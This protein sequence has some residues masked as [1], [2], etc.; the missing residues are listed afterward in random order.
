MKYTLTVDQPKTGDD[1]ST[2]SVSTYDIVV[3]EYK[4]DVFYENY[5]VS[6]FSR[7]RLNNS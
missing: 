6:L 5:N 3:K 7:K 2:S 4:T 1:I